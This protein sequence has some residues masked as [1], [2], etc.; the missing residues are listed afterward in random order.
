MPSIAKRR[1]LD[2][3]RAEVIPIDFQARRRPVPNQSPNESITQARLAA[4]YDLYLEHMRITRALREFQMQV[5]TDRAAG[6]NFETGDLV[7]DSDL[8]IVRRKSA[9]GAARF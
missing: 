2:R 5:E 8:K 4:G 3:A 7:F 6:A 1:G 9:R